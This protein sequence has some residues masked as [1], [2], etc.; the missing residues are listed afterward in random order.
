MT[1]DWCQSRKAQG[2]IFDEWEIKPHSS[3]KPNSSGATYLRTRQCHTRYVCSSYQSHRSNW[4]VRLVRPDR[5]LR[6]WPIPWQHKKNR[7][8]IKESKN[9]TMKYDDS[10]TRYKTICLWRIQLSYPCF[11]WLASWLS[12][13]SLYISY[14]IIRTNGSRLACRTVPN[15]VLIPITGNRK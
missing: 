7:P 13:I 2:L 1:S 12:F 15:T 5:G 3:E 11:G 4:C 14:F 6:L 8:K 10:T 9:L